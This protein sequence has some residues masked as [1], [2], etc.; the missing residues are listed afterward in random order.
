MT[1]ETL[2]LKGISYDLKKMAEFQISN[3]ADWRFTFI[4]SFGG[5]GACFIFPKW[6]IISVASFLVC[7]YHIVRYVMEYKKY[8]QQKK[9]IFEMIDRGDICIY[10]EK[11]SHKSEEIVYEPHIHI[12]RNHT[13]SSK[14]AE[15]FYFM[16]G[17]SWRIPERIFQH[18]KWSKDFYITSQ[19][20][21]NI[22]SMG[23]E[24]YYIS[25]NGHY[26]ISYIYPCEQ[27][28]LDKSLNVN[29]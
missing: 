9:A 11:F 17:R 15:F 26:E 28:V 21:F 13:H 18:Y 1:K 6:Y 22:S 8:R 25:L 20:L 29:I 3:V 2:T 24:F 14:P 27:F 12:Y 16:S 10:L 5:L 4:F 19:G 23:D 7:I